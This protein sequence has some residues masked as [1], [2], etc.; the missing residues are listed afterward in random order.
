MIQLSNGHSFE[1]S[2]ASGA[3]AF[4][5]RGWPWE[6]P[7]RWTGL[8]QP[9]LF[10]VVAKSLTLH[11]RRGN[12]RWSHP[13]SCVRSLKNGSVN[14]IGLTNPGIDAW[15]EK[16]YPQIIKRPWSM[17]AS[18]AGESL[19][20]NC[21]MAIKLRHCTALKALEIN[22]SCPNSPGELQS[23]AATVIDTCKVIRQSVALPIFVKLSVTQDYL[24]I[25]KALEGV[26]EA[27]SLN[28]VP[29]SVVFPDRVSPLAQFGGGGVSGKLAQRFTWK[30][31]EELSKQ[32]SI[33]VIGASVWD[34]EDIEKLFQ[35]GAKAIAFGSI[36][37]SH[38]CRPT[39]Y[40]KRWRH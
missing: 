5:G 10:T 23:N 15:I 40:V 14:A 8:I 1:F 34:F 33:P 35:L 3:L 2:V 31:I 19:Q 24:K 26:V 37:L 25:A 13:W 29:W 6:W 9:E 39:A 12:L 20:E 38:P 30:M 7:L 36:F 22:A 4:D 18:I 32:T 11:P 17:V 28:S 21:E 16:I 27:I